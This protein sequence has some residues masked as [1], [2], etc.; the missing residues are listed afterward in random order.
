[1]PRTNA[2]VLTVMWIAIAI[3]GYYA[4]LKGEAGM[5]GLIVVVGALTTATCRGKDVS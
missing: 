3:I 1:M 4:L 5:T 2:V